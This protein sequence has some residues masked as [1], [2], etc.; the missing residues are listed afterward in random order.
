[1]RL[2]SFLFLIAALVGLLMCVVT[3]VFYPEGIYGI[4]LGSFYS[5]TFL[6]L[7]FVIAISLTRAARKE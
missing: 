2:L 1:M 3:R 4:G 7:L 6:S 5:F